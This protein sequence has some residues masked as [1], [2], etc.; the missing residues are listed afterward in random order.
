[1]GAQV[2]GE[3]ARAQAVRQT[4]T[5]TGRLRA[6]VEAWWAVGT[7]RARVWG[8]APIRAA[9][10]GAQAKGARSR[11]QVTSQAIMGNEQEA[12]AMTQWTARV[13]WAY[14]R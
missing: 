12:G 8:C 4:T 5:A 1:M 9:T 10:A 11:A 7:A 14:G 6:R 3:G 13:F 2:E